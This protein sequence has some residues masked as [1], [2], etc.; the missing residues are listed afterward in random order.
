MSDPY[1]GEIRMFAGNF[2][3][4][5]WANCSGQMIAISQNNALFALLG[6]TYGG[7]GRTS[8]GL[9]DFRGRIPIH[10][11]RGNGLTPRFLGQRLG[12]ERETLS[13]NQ[14]PSHNHAYVASR[15][16]ADSSNPANDVMAS[17]SDG[18]QPYAGS[19]SDP[20]N[21]QQLNSQTIAFSGDSQSHN[22]I[23]PFLCVN[24]II[25]MVG[26]FPQR[27]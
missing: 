2:T 12:F 21:F 7:D 6:T 3:P 20:A 27:Q 18:D 11:G 9:P 14:M 15:D 23:M 19:P 22:N 25:C 8:F 16:D 4:R 17:Q 10:Q 26:A 13:T 24:F 1:I 5:S